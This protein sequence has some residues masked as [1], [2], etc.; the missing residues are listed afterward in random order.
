MARKA[1]LCFYKLIVSQLWPAG[2]VRWC[3]SVS[4]CGTVCSRFIS[5]RKHGRY[6]SPCCSRSSRSALVASSAVALGAFWATLPVERGIVQPRLACRVQAKMQPRNIDESSPH[7][8]RLGRQARSGNGL[9]RT[10]PFLPRPPPQRSA[11]RSA[12]AGARHAEEHYSSSP[13]FTV[14]AAALRTR[15]RWMNAR[16]RRHVE[17]AVLMVTSLGERRAVRGSARCRCR[18]RGAKKSLFTR[19][20]RRRCPRTSPCC[21]ALPTRPICRQEGSGAAPRHPLTSV[22][23][24]VCVPRRTPS[25]GGGSA[26]ARRAARRSRRGVVGRVVSGDGGMRSLFTASPDIGGGLL[27]RF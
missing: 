20:A 3:K 2:G 1:T 10:Y 21:P 25:V 26:R 7:P 6:L 27:I 15:R 13:P 11:G 9:P 24:A 4:R 16:T 8:L 17:P 18:Q 22:R 12:G 19:D 14:R 23:L 5:T